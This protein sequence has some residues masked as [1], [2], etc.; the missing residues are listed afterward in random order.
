MKIKGENFTIYNFGHAG[1]GMY[2][3]GTYKLNLK[4]SLILFNYDEIH[5]NKFYP[6]KNYKKTEKIV[7]KNGDLI[8]ENY[9]K[10]KSDSSNYKFDSLFIKCKN[11]LDKSFE[12]NKQR[13]L[14]KKI[15]KK[16]F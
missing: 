11:Y 6:L 13:G 10:D 1:H 5:G 7:L 3:W 16:D 4:D 9:S 14:L 2:G 12:T 8:L 15:K